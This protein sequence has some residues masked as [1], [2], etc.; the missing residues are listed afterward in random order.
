MSKGKTDTIF[1]HFVDVVDL[2]ADV[3]GPCAEVV[4]HDFSKKGATIV[5]IRNGH[6]TGRSVGDS[7]TDLGLK[8]FR[9]LEK[10]HD[11]KTCLSNYKGVLKDGRE[12]KCGSLVIRSKGTTIGA[13]CINIDLQSF[14]QVQ[15]FLNSFCECL[16][17]DQAATPAE[18]FMPKYSSLVDQAIDKTRKELGRVH[19]LL[20]KED[21]LI[22]VRSLDQ[23]GVFMIRGAVSIVSQRLRLAAPTVYKY[24]AR[25]RSGASSKVSRRKSKGVGA[26]V[27]GTQKSNSEGLA[28]FEFH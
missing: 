12:L 20:G 4:L 25:A 26:R 13:L 11:G 19:G 2:F 14:Q 17:L 27:V 1:S 9:D 28:E 10:E 16:S 21:K 6:V 23:Q 22:L 24:L 3:L 15:S 18:S 5:K 8:M 7:V